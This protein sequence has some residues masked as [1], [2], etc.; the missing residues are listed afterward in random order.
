M[1][2]VITR[3]T[4][5]RH[6]L[7]SMGRLVQERHQARRAHMAVRQELPATYWPLLLRNVVTIT[8]TYVC[9]T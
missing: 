1:R 3:K 6:A 9:N 5:N 4:W 8:S 7:L 2:S